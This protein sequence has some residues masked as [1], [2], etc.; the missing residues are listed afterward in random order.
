MN[1]YEK[2]FE[3]DEYYYSTRYNN[4]GAGEMMGFGFGVWP[5]FKGR[6]FPASIRTDIGDSLLGYAFLRRNAGFSSDKG[7]GIYRGCLCLVL[8]CLLSEGINHCLPKE[9]PLGIDT[10]IGYLCGHHLLTA[11]CLCWRNRL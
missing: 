9:W 11:Y 5:G 3:D 2:V 6:L 10:L 4:T 8:P 1:K 7:P